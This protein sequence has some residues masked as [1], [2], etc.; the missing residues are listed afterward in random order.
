MVDEGA[1]TA[2]ALFALHPVQVESVAWMSE[3]KNTLSGVFYLLA[4]FAYFRFDESRDRRWYLAAFAAFVLALG[5]KTV[6]ATLP[7]ALAVVLWWRHGRLDWRRDLLPLVPMLI[8]GVAPASRLRGW[9]S[10]GSEHRAGRSVERNPARPARRSRRM[11]LRRESRVAG[12]ADVHVPALVESTR[13]ALWQYVFPIPLVAVIAALWWMRHRRRGRSR[14]RCS[15]ANI[16]SSAWVRERVSVSLL[17]R[18]GP[19][20]VS[21][22]SRRAVPLAI[23]VTSALQRWRPGLQNG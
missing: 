7:A 10:P 13:P 23:G 5:S 1:I 12:A 3:L 18:R 15:S 22:D 19:L 14:Q 11:V 8:V 20:S 4:A 17:V 21:G 16:Y 6:T 9:K 2:A